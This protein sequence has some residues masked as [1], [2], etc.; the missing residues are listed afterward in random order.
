[1][2]PYSSPQAVE[3]WSNACKNCRDANYSKCEHSTLCIRSLYKA[4]VAEE[5]HLIFVEEW[6]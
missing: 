6:Q 5:C 3:F 2:C 4:K 1:M